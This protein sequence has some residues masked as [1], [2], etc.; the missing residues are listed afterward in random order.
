M[1]CVCVVCTCVRVGLFLWERALGV[2]KVSGKLNC[3][4]QELEKQVPSAI[5]NNMVHF[6]MC[7]GTSWTL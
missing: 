3:H 6:Q 4:W 2:D 1:V 5:N 7:H